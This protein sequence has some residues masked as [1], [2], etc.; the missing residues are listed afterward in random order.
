VRKPGSKSGPSGKSGRHKL[1]S[2]TRAAGYTGKSNWPSHRKD[3][4]IVLQRIADRE[5]QLAQTAAAA[6]ASYSN[7]V[8]AQ[9]GMVNCSMCLDLRSGAFSDSFLA[10]AVANEF[11]PEELPSGMGL[12]T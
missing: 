2:R 12:S 11:T 8:R 10:R 5:L 1:G 9:R 3:D 4:P 7:R 6:Q